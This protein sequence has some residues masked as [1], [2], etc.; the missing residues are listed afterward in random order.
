MTWL[1]ARCCRPPSCSPTTPRC[2]C[3]IPAAAGPRRDGC[4]ATPSMI[5][6]G[7][8][9][10]TLRQPMC[11]PRTARVRVPLD[12]WPASVACSRSTAMPASSG[13]PGIAPTALCAWRSAGPTCGGRSTSSLPPPRHHWPPRCWCASASSTRS[14]LRSGA[15]PPSIEDKYAT[16]EVDRSSKPCMPGC[17]TTW[18]VS[19]PRPISRKP[20]AMRY[21]T[22]PVWWCS[23][24][25][26]AS[27]WTPT[28]S[29]ERSG[30]IP[31]LARMRCSR[32]PTRVR[33]AAHQ[34]M[35]L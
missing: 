18:S 7:A 5:A 13:W 21:A 32:V 35:S 25:M 14:R 6:R 1:S 4:G 33:L 34:P 15:I 2:R 24:T 30:P 19:P 12:T 29:R 23:S 3:S 17:R 27:R 26:A 20:F 28:W 9:H 8:D 11:I 10:L 31:S 22:G 16:S